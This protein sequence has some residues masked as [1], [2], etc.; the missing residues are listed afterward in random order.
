MPHLN[1]NPM[2]HPLRAGV[3]AAAAQGGRSLPLGGARGRRLALVAAFSAAAMALS[4]TVVAGSPAERT[5]AEGSRSGTFAG[6][7]SPRAAP[8]SAAAGQPRSR[9]RT[10]LSSAGEGAE[11]GEAGGGFGGTRPMLQLR[12]EAQPF[13]SPLTPG[14]PFRPA[15]Q[16]AAFA[17]P[18]MPKSPKPFRPTTPAERAGLAYSGNLPMTMT[19]WQF[20]RG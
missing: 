2:P 8:Q 20:S 19:A 9:V 12:R 14:D 13:A 5:A 4:G 15:V 17:A 10:A 18:T 6:R 16:P 3:A 7:D 1:L 11:L